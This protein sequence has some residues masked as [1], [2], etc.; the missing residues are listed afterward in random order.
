MWLTSTCANASASD[1]HLSLFLIQ[2]KVENVR[3]ND[4]MVN[5]YETYNLKQEM[6]IFMCKRRDYAD[7]QVKCASKNVGIA[8]SRFI[9]RRANRLI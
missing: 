3:I 7:A 5:L 1:W 2:Q 9:D 4:F 6:Q 8:A